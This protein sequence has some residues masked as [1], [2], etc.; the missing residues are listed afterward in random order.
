MLYELGAWHVFS[1][2]HKVIIHARRPQFDLSLII[3]TISQPSQP[4]RLFS[5]PALPAQIRV[6]MA[7]RPSVQQACRLGLLDPRDAAGLPLPPA[8][9]FSFQVIAVSLESATIRAYRRGVGWEGDE[10]GGVEADE[11]EG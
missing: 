8:E 3:A 6:R 1:P 7:V 4:H 5:T 2:A 10:G 9:Y 11:T